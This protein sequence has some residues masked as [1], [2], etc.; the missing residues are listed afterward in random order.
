M[1]ED[2]YECRLYDWSGSLLS[3]LDTWRSLSASIRINGISSHQISMDSNDPKVSLFKKDYIFEIRRRNDL[4]DWQTIY[5]GF[6]R[7]PQYQISVDGY[8][9]FTSYGR[10]FEDL[11][12][13]R[14]LA[15]AEP[16]CK[17]GPADNVMKALVRE[18]CTLDARNIPLTK[19]NVC[20]V[21]TGIYPD[22]PPGTVFIPGFFEPPPPPLN[23][24]TTVLTRIKDG[25]FLNFT[26]A[27]DQSVAPEWTGDRAYKNLLDVLQEISLSREV[28]F[29]VIPSPN[30]GSFEFKT[31]YPLG[32]DRSVTSGVVPH[33]FAPE[34]GNVSVP[35]FVI[36]ATEEVTTLIVLGS[37]SLSTRNKLVNF[38]QDAFDSPW[39]D[40]ELIRDARNEKSPNALDSIIDSELAKAGAKETL[41]FDVIQ[42]PSSTFGLHYFL[43][44]LV[45]MRM[46]TI[47]R[48]KR[49]LGVDLNVSESVNTLKFNFG[50]TEYIPNDENAVVVHVIR[51][52]VKRVQ[53][54]E[55][56]GTI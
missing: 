14:S 33:I 28:D 44:D 35:S 38:T 7:T 8:E 17:S 26:V 32:T 18:N 25:T 5:L 9:I 4:I 6:H 55:H 20:T 34:F 11:L 36:S 22:F 47:V 49:I 16:Y 30:L 27:E 13:R 39:N 21:F 43:G 2:R 10:S 54:I 45:T 37:G 51:N 56:S 3:V 42:T 41:T 46:G 24:T 1:S 31:Y 50:D 53:N 48:D 29:A 12:R 52:L 19:Q 15:Y 40:I 23:I